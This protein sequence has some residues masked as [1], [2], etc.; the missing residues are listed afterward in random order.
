MLLTKAFEN[1][2]IK[3][4]EIE[5]KAVQVLLVNSLIK[6][7]SYFIKIYWIFLIISNLFCKKNSPLL[8]NVFSN[9]K[10][11]MDTQLLTKVQFHISFPLFN[12][13]TIQIDIKNENKNE[14]N[15]ILLQ[16]M[17]QIINTLNSTFKYFR[18]GNKIK[19]I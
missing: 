17:N 7:F 6:N 11:K 18:K 16:E 10:V 12:D 4:F 8:G 9:F 3:C 14:S 19:R 13:I 2:L 5:G 15:L 1:V